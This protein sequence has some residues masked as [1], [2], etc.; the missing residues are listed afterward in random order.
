MPDVCKVVVELGGWFGAPGVNVWNFCAPAHGEITTAHANTFLE[1][2]R[3]SYAVEPNL[4]ATGVTITFPAT[5]PVFNSLTGELLY[6][7]GDESAQAQVTGTGNSS[8]SRASQALL[9]LQTSDVR[10]NRLV[11]GHVFLGP[12]AGNLIDS[13][14]TI[15]SYMREDIT[16]A[17]SGVIDPLA[18]RVVVWSRPINEDGGQVSD[19]NTVS[20]RNIPATLR[21]RNR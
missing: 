9:R 18:G 21:G 17:F 19:V 2:L 15:A 12:M 5:L 10:A 7:V 11:R 16:E 14:G 6:F 1:D 13:D 3:T 8:E 20:V 4:Y